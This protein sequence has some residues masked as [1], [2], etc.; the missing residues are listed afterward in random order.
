[1]RQVAPRNIARFN[2]KEHTF[3]FDPM[4]EQTIV[5]YATDGW[6]LH[7]GSEE[8]KKQ[9]DLEKLEQDASTRCVGS[10]PLRIT[11]RRHRGSELTDQFMLPVGS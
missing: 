8:A 9:L 4:V 2:M 7:K 5:H 1:M 11:R 6:L 3:K 10:R